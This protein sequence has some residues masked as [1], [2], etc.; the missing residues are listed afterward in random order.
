MYR[1]ALPLRLSNV[2]DMFHVSMLH[3]Y[4]PNPFHVLSVDDIDVN[5]PYVDELIQILDRKEQ[6]LRSHP[7]RKGLV[8]ASR[9]R[10]DYLRK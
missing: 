5:G 2:H 9:I 1:L 3:K 10:E 6:V 8:D 4:E 7:S